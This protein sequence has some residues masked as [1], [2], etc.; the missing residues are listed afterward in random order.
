MRFLL[1]LL[2][3][4]SCL[5]LISCYGV[6]SLISFDRLAC[7]RKGITPQE[8]AKTLHEEPLVEMEMKVDGDTY[9]FQVYNMEIGTI[10]FAKE[11]KQPSSSSSG[12]VV[13]STNGSYSTQKNNVSCMMNY[14][15]TNQMMM[16]NQMMMG[17]GNSTRTA[18][19]DYFLIFCDDRLTYWGFMYELKASPKELYNKLATEIEKKLIMHA[20]E[21]WEEKKEER[22]KKFKDRSSGGMV[23][24]E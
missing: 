3:V 5:L 18:M 7:L 10:H 17:C 13:I 6:E 19:C 16:H 22:K 20:K 1:M 8:A 14:G 24:E 15:M 9:S 21:R 12:S 2:I 11:A 23:N 4:L